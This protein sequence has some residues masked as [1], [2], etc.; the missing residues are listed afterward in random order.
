MTIRGSILVVLIAVSMGVQMSAQEHQRITLD[1]GG[2]TVYLGM[3]LDEY[4]TKAAAAGY[5]LLEEG[6]VVEGAIW[7]SK[8]G[9]AAYTARFVGGKLVVR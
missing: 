3:S 5:Q 4:K 6:G 1:Q 7:T 2:M 9:G 8:S